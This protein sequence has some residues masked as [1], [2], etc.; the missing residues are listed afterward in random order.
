MKAREI[1]TKH[2]AT[3]TEDDPILNAVQIMKQ[4]DCGAVPVTD[5]QGRCVGIV[6]DRDI[7]LEVVLKGLGPE[8]S[9]LR[10][11]MSSHPVTCN[12]QEDIERVL[13]KMEE[14]QI[15]RIPVVDES[16]KCVGIIA[17]AD[18]ALKVQEKEKVSELVEAVSR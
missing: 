9:R 5:L 8:K 10:E 4:H 15:R 12:P 16:G 2:P 11:I 18:L 14:H 7:C 1:M 17:Q 3:C 6:T 13:Q